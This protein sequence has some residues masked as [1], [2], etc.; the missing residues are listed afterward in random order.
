MN[1]TNPR[2]EFVGWVQL[3]QMC[4]ELVHRLD[5]LSFN[6]IVS[7]SR[8]GHVVSRIVSDFLNLPLLNVTRSSGLKGRRKNRSIP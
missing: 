3:Q 8:G 6:V 1:M 2:L 4:F 5:G 7:I